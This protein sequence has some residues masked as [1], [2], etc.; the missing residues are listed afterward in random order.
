MQKL[1]IAFTFGIHPYTLMKLC[2]F[3][4]AKENGG[5]SD[6]FG[7]IYLLLFYLTLVRLDRYILLLF[8]FLLVKSCMLFLISYCLGFFLC[9]VHG[10]TSGGNLLCLAYDIG[11]DVTILM[12]RCFRLLLH[13]VFVLILNLFLVSLVFWIFCKILQNGIQVSI[14]CGSMVIWI[15][16]FD[17]QTDIADSSHVNRVFL[18]V[19]LEMQYITIRHRKG[20][21]LVSEFEIH[22][23]ISH[24]LGDFNHFLRGIL[25]QSKTINGHSQIILTYSTEQLISAAYAIVIY[26]SVVFV[27]SQQAIA[28]IVRCTF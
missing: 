6:D 20:W 12:G 2:H 13:L 28:R 26:H 21:H 9:L 10:N 7:C 24:F 8:F 23:F 15:A 14:P 4:C 5:M 1:R 18:L 3:Q 22:L 19:V 27:L 17:H 16:M 25:L 11:L